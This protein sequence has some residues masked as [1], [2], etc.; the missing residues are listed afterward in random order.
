M[1]KDN[2]NNNNNKNNN[3]RRTRARTTTPT[4]TRK[5]PGRQVNHQPRLLPKLR[6]NA[7]KTLFLYAFMAWIKRLY[8]YIYLS[9]NT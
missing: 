5:P 8:I 4:T 7:A 9:L 6:L 1:M 2:N 3:S